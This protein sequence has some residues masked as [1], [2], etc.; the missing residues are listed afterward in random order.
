M[1]NKPPVI[2]PTSVSLKIN[3]TS[4]MLYSNKYVR[5]PDGSGASSQHYL[6]SFPCS[7]TELPADFESLLRTATTGRPERYTALIERIEAE[8]LIPARRRAAEELARRNLIALENALNWATQ[9]VTAIPEMQA[10]NELIEHPG[11]QQLLAKLDEAT[12]R[13]ASRIKPNSQT[14]LRT[15]TT[16]NST[17]AEERLK[18]LLTNLED[19]CLEIGTLLPESAQTFKRGYVFEDE[20][21]SLVKRN[22]FRTSDVIARLGSRAQ[23]RRP[24]G[25]SAL[26]A[27]ILR[28]ETE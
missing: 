18:T 14:V 24:A 26:R 16:E 5:L 8:V 20:T 11:P 23:F 1:P 21:V 9:N 6:A 15:A 13:L 2:A 10:Y 12:Y 22:W 27:P 4:V 7:A 25:W 28:D 17:T 19:I 3:R